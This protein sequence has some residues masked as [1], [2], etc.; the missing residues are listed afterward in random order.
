[1]RVRAA[2]ETCRNPELPLT[3]PG[4]SFSTSEGKTLS[5]P[6]PLPLEALAAGDRDE[7][8]TLESQTHSLNLKTRFEIFQTK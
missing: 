1:M 2:R 6:P 3:F 4:A 8:R 5:P 7:S